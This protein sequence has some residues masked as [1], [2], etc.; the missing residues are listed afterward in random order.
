MRRPGPGPGST[1]RSRRSLPAR[2]V[3]PVP[4]RQNG[5]SGT[6]L[7]AA[8]FLGAADFL[9]PVAFLAAFLA[10]PADFLAPAAFFGRLLG[11][12][13]LLRP[14]L[15]GPGLL[16]GGGAGGPA[17]GQQLGG[18]LHGDRLDD[19]TLAQR[20]VRR[21]IGDIGPEAP[22]LDHD[23]ELGGRVGPSSRSG[24]AAVRPR[25][26]L[27]CA[28][29]AW[30]SGRVTVRIW[31]SLARLRVSVP[32]FRYGPNLPLWATTSSPLSGSVPTVRGMRSSSRAWAKV[33]VA[34]SMVE[35]SDEVRGL[36]PP[37]V[38]SPSWT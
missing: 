10:A 30:A 24:G 13:G 5:S 9:A 38:A 25:R 31:S 17:L 32:I 20:C 28:N 26:C 12:P 18:P 16:A 14:G 23:G 3:G 29:S 2:A 6:A 27:G 36:A 21:P 35:K 19:V 7:S 37:S 33:R 22:L 34:G 4:A 1:S 8:A 15:L 11:H